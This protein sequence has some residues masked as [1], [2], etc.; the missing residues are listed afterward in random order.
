MNTEDRN[1]IKEERDFSI[2][3][4]KAA[5]KSDFHELFVKLKED[6]SQSLECYIKCDYMD[7]EPV[8]RRGFPNH[9]I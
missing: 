3:E 2:L 6:A 8:H 4:I 7:V 1:E 9:T 5:W